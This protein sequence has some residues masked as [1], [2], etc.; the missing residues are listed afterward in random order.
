MSMVLSLYMPDRKFM[1]VSVTG[2]ECAL[3][4][5]H[6]KARFLRHMRPALDPETLYRLALEAENARYVGM[7]V[8][9]GSD[10]TG[11]VPLAGYFNTLKNIK[12]NTNL[13]LNVHTGFIGPEEVEALAGTGMDIVSFDI[14]GS[15]SVLADVYGLSLEEGYFDQIL[16]CFKQHGM[17][18]VP[19]ITAGL[20]RGQD[21][22]EERAL[23]IIAAHVLE[24]VI[25]NSL[26]PE[27]GERMTSHRLDIVLQMASRILPA[28][29]S[30]GIGCMR[31]R[32]I[33]IKADW[34]GRY[35]IGSI[36]VPS[37]LLVGE[38]DARKIPY[39]KKEGCC[40]LDVL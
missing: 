4:C 39:E 30:I 17:T 9:G 21:S 1:T 18:V 2:E 5:R 35:R 29:T 8:S 3:M 23:K 28:E 16:D 38:L 22:G 25:I 26:L 36:A 14:V 32:E 34:L 37:R 19:H 31:P 27:S 24:M 11:R 20:D 10:P 7:L 6:C 12:K 33:G 40:A 15:A 13:I